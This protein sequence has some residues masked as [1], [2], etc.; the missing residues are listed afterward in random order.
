[1]SPD[2]DFKPITTNSNN[3][4]MKTSK[5]Q[6]DSDFEVWYEMQVIAGL[7]P[8]QIE[9]SFYLT[10]WSKPRNNK[11]PMNQFLTSINN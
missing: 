4:P 11:E 9:E 10:K 7:T 8:D 1:M 5:Q 3:E 2:D 6:V